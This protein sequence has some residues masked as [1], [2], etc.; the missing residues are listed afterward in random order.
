[1]LKIFSTTHTPN[2]LPCT[3]LFGWHSFISKRVYPNHSSFN[4]RP[5][6]RSRRSSSK[7]TMDSPPSNAIKSIANKHTDTDTTRSTDIDTLITRMTTYMIQCMRN[8]DPSHNPHHVHRVVHLAHK[9]LASER[10]NLPQSTTTYDD[11][12]VTLAALLHDIG[13][14][15][16]LPAPNPTTATT[17][18][19]DALLSNG[20]DPCL[21]ARV[22]MVVSHVSFSTEMKDP[23]LIRRLIFEEG[24]P[25]LA[26]VQDADRLDALGAV[27]IGRCFTYLGA[28]GQGQGSWEL[29]EAIEHF[30]EKLERLEGM[31]KTE[32]GREMA[33][34]RTERLRE[35]R[36]WWVDENEIG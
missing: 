24:Y 35:F 13:D 1:M 10:E 33:R 25:E 7:Q 36:R 27:G 2:I 15:K 20:A 6:T 22:R 32:S 18:V 8:H 3:R 34:V 21:A 14:R 30:G 11:T 29:D 5:L 17:I 12:V 4:H 9:L 23:D 26:I 16:Y 19:Y 31:M 28:K